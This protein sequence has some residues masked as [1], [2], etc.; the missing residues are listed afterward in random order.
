MTDIKDLVLGFAKEQ[1]FNEADFNEATI[2][3]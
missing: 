3:A 2:L 1:R